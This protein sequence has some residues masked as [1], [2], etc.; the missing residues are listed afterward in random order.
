MVFSKIISES[1][2]E[3]GADLNTKWKANELRKIMTPAELKLWKRLRGNKIKGFH[4]RRQHP[5]G[6]YILDFYCNKAN[7]AIEVDGDIHKFKK[8]YDQERTKYL[9]ESGIKVLRFTNSE[10]EEFIEIVLNRIKS[11]L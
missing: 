7:L 1:K 8:E 4:F 3:H 9:E 11:E 5:Y 2:Q 6:I 10:V